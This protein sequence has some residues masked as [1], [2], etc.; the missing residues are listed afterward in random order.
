M[1]CLVTGATGYLGSYL[2][3]HLVEQGH[4][5]S[6]LVRPSAD[7]S[8]L[9]SILDRIRV[10]SGDLRSIGASGS[11]ITD[12]AP[13]TV[14]HLAWSGVT[15]DTRNQ[16]ANIAASVSGSLHLFALTQQAGCSTWIGIGSQAEYGFQDEILREDSVPAPDTP[17][18][19]AKLGLCAILSALSRHSAMRFVWLR[20][21]AAYG[22]ADDPRHLIPFMI[23]R[24]LEGRDVSLE[25]TGM[26]EWDYLYV[27]DAVNAICLA[28]QNPDLSGVYNL[29]SGDWTS[30][31]RLAENIRRAVNPLAALDFGSLAS[32]S[33]RAD[34]SRLKRAL[35]WKPETSIETGLA[36]TIEWHRNRTKQL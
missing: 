34:V 17:Y 28:A 9:E 19:A 7:L 29:A 5:V 24:F 15:A 8:V 6:V 30:V 35:N 23:T 31:R 36:A 18:G 2:T 27:Q 26:Q 33:V 21:F 25:S 10:I 3:R 22:P 32:G 13:E 11:A 4:D 12:I 1:R 20:L 14:F 16:P